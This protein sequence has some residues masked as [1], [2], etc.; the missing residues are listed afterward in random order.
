MKI[1][2]RMANI[3]MSDLKEIWF[4]FQLL[5]FV[6]AER[7]SSLRRPVPVKQDED[8]RVCFCLFSV[9]EMAVGR[10]TFHPMSAV[11]QRL[12]QRPSPAG[13]GRGLAWATCSLRPSGSSFVSTAAEF[14]KHVRSNRPTLADKKR[15][16]L[17]R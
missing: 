9:L 11:T 8:Q 4:V 7:E 17:L 12:L 2:A 14:F 3:H 1:L 6:C 16:S 5:F 10:W 15:D 13:R